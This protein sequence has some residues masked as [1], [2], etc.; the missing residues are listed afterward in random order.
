MMRID[1]LKDVLGFT[2]GLSCV[3]WYVDFLK[4]VKVKNGL[5]VLREVKVEMGEEGAE[6]ITGAP[7]Y[8]FGGTL[9]ECELKSGTR[10]LIINWQDGEVY[11][12]DFPFLFYKGTRYRYEFISLPCLNLEEVIKKYL[13]EYL[14]TTKG[15]ANEGLVKV[16]FS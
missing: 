2:I 4:S 6:Y 5:V 10:E 16:E 14:E 12:C 13:K 11:V 3:R 7:Q 1:Y 9:L 15:E 8:I